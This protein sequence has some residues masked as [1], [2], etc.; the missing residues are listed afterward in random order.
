[1]I[2]P[3]TNNVGQANALKE[4]EQC[5]P[6]EAEKTKAISNTP[7]RRICDLRLQLHSARDYQIIREDT[8]IVHVLAQQVLQGLSDGVAL[9]HDAFAAV[10]TCARGIR[11]QSGTT[12]DALQALLQRGTETSLAECQRV[13]NDLVLKGEKRQGEGQ[14]RNKGL[15][16]STACY[17][18]NIHAK[19]ANTISDYRFFRRGEY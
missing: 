18:E 2:L 12:Y 14:D 16:Q 19:Y 7:P 11:H 17:M 1:M 15:N 5:G 8:Y 3:V 13:Q 10:V 4:R 9:G 6:D